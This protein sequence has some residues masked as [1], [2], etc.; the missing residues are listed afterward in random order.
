MSIETIIREIV[1]DELRKFKETLHEPP[2]IEPIPLIETEVLSEEKVTL[3]KKKLGRK[4][5]K[6]VRTAEEVA[7][8]MEK[9]VE[10]ANEIVQ[11]AKEETKPDF[12]LGDKR[13]ARTPKRDEI[14][15]LISRSGYTQNRE[16]RDK[17][18]SIIADYVATEFREEAALL[19]YV[20]EEALDTMMSDLKKA[21]NK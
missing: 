2:L 12:P 9:S 10:S 19:L 4:K 11:K 18:K 14:G 21:F 8:R 20:P 7:Q 6:P 1:A 3:K 17:M 16:S 15:R 5:K 13:Y